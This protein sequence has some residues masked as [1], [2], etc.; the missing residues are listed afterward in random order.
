MVASV[1]HLATATRT[2]QDCGLR[3]DVPPGGSPRL[4][5]P[6]RYDQSDQ[7]PGRGVNSGFQ[8]RAQIVGLRDG[9]ASFVLRLSAYILAMDSWEKWLRMAAAHS[10]FCSISTAPMRRRT[11]WRLRKMATTSA[12]RRSPG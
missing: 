2:E 4:V 12:R 8:G 1:G 6:P 3:A 10:S 5:D 7:V 9:V 11:D